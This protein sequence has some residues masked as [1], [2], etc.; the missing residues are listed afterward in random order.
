MPGLQAGNR[1]VPVMAA[2]RSCS[3]ASRRPETTSQ[4]LMWDE[5]KGRYLSAG[6]CH[7]CAAQAAWGHQ[8]GFAGLEYQPCEICRGTVLPATVTNRHGSRGQEWLLRAA[9]RGSAPAGNGTG[10][11]HP[12]GVAVQAIPPSRAAQ[13]SAG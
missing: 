12:P 2:N 7:G 9:L 11:D 5:V 1:G 6:L 4:A 8:I 3:D 13:G 10:S